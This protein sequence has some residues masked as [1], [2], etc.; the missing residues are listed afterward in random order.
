MLINIKAKY[1]IYINNVQIS[2]RF[3]PACSWAQGHGGQPK[4]NPDFIE[5]KAG[6]HILTLKVS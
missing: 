6:C 5:R 3:D 2:S 4:P 1:D